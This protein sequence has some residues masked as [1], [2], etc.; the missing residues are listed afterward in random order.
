MATAKPKNGKTP[1]RGPHLLRAFSG[2]GVQGNPCLVT[3]LEAAPRQ[4]PTHADI[5]Q[6]VCWP[7]D[8]RRV[9][10]RCWSTSGHEIQ[11]CGHGLLS[12][13]HLWRTAWP[14]GG[15]LQMGSSD[16][17]VKY[18]GDHSWLGFATLPCELC[19]VPPWC[20]DRFGSTPIA[21]ATAGDAR[22]YIVL[23]W[24]DDGALDTLAAPGPGLSGDTERAVIATCRDPGAGP[25]RIRLRYFAPQHGVAEDV[26]TGSAMR[27]LASYWYLQAM[28]RDLSARQDSPD[29]GAL[30]SRI[31]GDTTWVGGRAG[32]G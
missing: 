31:D 17:A 3:V 29:G 9:R 18:D 1:T 16:I 10:V 23:Q 26:A 15:T 22:G 13:A 4:P 30:F 5:T 27:V 14:R 7:V 20:A 32:A 12:C 2:P 11:C 28:L 24:P 25:G 19:P 8:A 6:C 21:A